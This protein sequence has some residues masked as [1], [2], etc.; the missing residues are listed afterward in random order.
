MPRRAAPARTNA[1]EEL[2]TA[3]DLKRGGAVKSLAQRRR[4]EVVGAE[5][6]L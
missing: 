2:Y 3:Y 5:E 6:A 1:P 4:C